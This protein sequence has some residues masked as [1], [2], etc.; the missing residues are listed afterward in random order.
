MLFQVW[1]LKK[2]FDQFEVKGKE[3]VE[4]RNIPTM[5]RMLSIHATMGGVE[6]TCRQMGL[7]KDENLDFETFVEL[8]SK[9]Y[10]EEDEETTK[11]ELKEAFRYIYYGKS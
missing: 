5:F 9:F 1:N 4:M 7:R 8:S 6:H 3:S 10:T 11:Y 2:A